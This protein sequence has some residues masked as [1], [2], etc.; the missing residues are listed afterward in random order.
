V[1]Y[2]DYN[3]TTPLD[4]VVLDAMLPWMTDQFWNAASSH[5]GGRRAADAVE[6]A[7]EQVAALLGGRLGE[8]VWTSGATEAANLAIKGTMEAASPDQTKFITFAT[9]HKCV[10]DVGSWLRT[11][12][13]DVLVLEVDTDGRPR[14]DQ[15]AAELDRGGVRLVSMMAANNETGVLADLVAAGTL[16]HAA[17]TLLH[18]DATQLVGKL[19][20]DVADSGAD[21]TSLSAHKI[22]GPKGIGA[23]MVR[24]GVRVEPQLHGGGHERGLRSGTVNV[25]GAVGFGI[26]AAQAGDIGADEAVRQAILIESFVGA[27]MESVSDV[28]VV[29]NDVERLPNTACVRIEGADAEAVM[30]NA[31]DVL[32]SSGSACTSLTPEPSHVLLAMGLERV[33]ATECLRVSVGRPTTSSDVELAAAEL[34]RAA[35]RVRGLTV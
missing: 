1:I 3:A 17:D 22:Y 26:A 11:R 7:R 25:A 34:G 33:A 30:V 19:A 31:P 28:S 15:L 5:A 32:V 27:L 14:L 12:G 16:C 29:A 24:R 8:I 20:F 13:Y 9:E 10:L 18:T 6:Q 35:A 21:L 2:L 23:L 4:P